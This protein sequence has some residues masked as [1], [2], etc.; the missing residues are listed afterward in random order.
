MSWQLQILGAA[1]LSQADKILHPERKTLGVLS[2]LALEGATPRSKLAGLLWA[3]SDERTARNNLVQVIRRLKKA[4]DTTLILGD[5]LLSL[6]SDINTD[7][8]Q[9]KVLAFAG[10]SKLL[11]FSGELLAPYDYDDC[12]DFADWLFAER[13]RIQSLKHHA[14]QTLIQTHQKD[15]NYQEALRCADALLQLDT[16]SEESHCLV[17][18]LHF[19]AGDRAAALKAFE[20]CKEILDKELGVEPTTDTHSLAAEIEFGSLLPV[21]SKAKADIPLRVLRPPLIGRETLLADMHTAWDKT[22][23]IVLRGEPGVGKSRLLKDFLESKGAY[24]FFEGRPGDSGVPYIT[25]SRILRQVLNLYEVTL[26]PWQRKELSRLLPELGDTPEPLTSETDQLRFYEAQAVVLES[27]FEKGMQVIAIDDLQFFDEASFKSLYFVL[28]KHW[29]KPNSLQMILSYRRG[30]LNAESETSLKDM[31]QAGSGVLLDLAPLSN[32]QVQEL[33]NSLGIADIE[34]LQKTLHSYTGGNPLF[35]IETIKSLLESDPSDRTFKLPSSSKVQTLLQQ[36]LEKLSQGA[37]RIAW[38]A[39]VAQT[40]F[41][42]EL[43][44]HITQQ[45]VFDLAEPLTE[46]EQRNIFEGQKFSHD[47]IF[48]T[49]LA[50]IS[51]PVRVYLHK[52]MAEYLEKKEANPARVAGHYLNAGHEKLAVPYL[53]LSAKQSMNAFRHDNAF[54]LYIQASEI[55]ERNRENEQAFKILHLALDLA[56]SSPAN[57]I[58]YLA[59]EL[60]RLASQ[61][62]EKA[63]A[64]RAQAAQYDLEGDLSG[65]EQA[66][67]KGLQFTADSSYPE[68]EAQ[69]REIL[70]ASILYQGRVDEALSEYQKAYT[71]C[72]KMGTSSALANAASSL[73]IVLDHLDRYTEA[74]EYYQRALHFFEALNHTPRL[75]Q[76]LND[77]GFSLRESGKLHEASSKLNHSLELLNQVT[78]IPDD[79][80]R[81]HA[82]FGETS[83]QLNHFQIALDHLLQAQHI[84]TQHNIGAPTIQI[85]MA[86][87]LTLLGQFD[88]AQA[89]L[90]TALDQ[91]LR[92]QTKGGLYLA[93]ARLKFNQEGQIEPYFSLAIKHLYAKP[94]S[95]SQLKLNLLQAPVEPPK[96]ALELAKSAHAIALKKPDSFAYQIGPLTRLAQIY[97]RLKKIALALQHSEKAIELIQDHGS[98]FYLGEVLLTHYQALSACKDTT[99]QSYLQQTLTW[100]IDIADNNVPS[101]YRQSFL[102]NNPVNKAI[103]EAAHKIGL[104]V[105]N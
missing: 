78:G 79:A 99:A 58:P 90:E 23:A 29:G 36:R 82:Q 92:E 40:D 74:S 20:R 1:S 71:L 57:R 81:C 43:A 69:L 14:L 15:S 34:P 73:A 60:T 24:T 62:L 94:E 6:S 32:S 88:E 27:A 16:L 39:A 37:L 61:P 31:V 68:L 42:L 5:D 87:V 101:E 75:I 80:W 41:S 28:G 33:V 104:T 65:A 51:A 97:L 8:A 70:A 7:A 59:K 48:E 98:D 100:L 56:D 3:E 21:A 12:P 53:V 25:Q 64:L 85:S 44:S 91:P 13:E 77:Y 47:L 86:R 96:K 72:Q 18:R 84:S 45:S 38:T 95:V 105:P 54:N 2:Y 49:A 4:T 46:L 11:N 103:L 10:D 35:M 17:M 22:Q 66:A 83:A 76:T 9:L 26:E 102:N 19:L 30:E 67:R 55:L 50:S 63:I 89:R 52:Q 93:L